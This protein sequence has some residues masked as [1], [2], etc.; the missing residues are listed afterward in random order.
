MQVRRENK[1]RERRKGRINI[2]ILKRRN[3]I[4]E[5]KYQTK[6]GST[7]ARQ[8]ARS[9]A[10]HLLSKLSDGPC[11]PASLPVCPTL[12]PWTVTL[13]VYSS[14]Q[15]IYQGYCISVG[16]SFYLPS[17]PQL[18]QMAFQILQIGKPLVC[19]SWPQWLSDTI[20]EILNPCHSCIFLKFKFRTMWMTL[21]G[22]VI[23]LDTWS[24]DICGSIYSS[25]LYENI[26]MP[27]AFF[28]CRSL[29]G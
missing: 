13:P 14:P 27:Y 4:I 22:L 20:G 23:N 25:L 21:T 9:V 24:I 17:F 7:P 2:T 26:K 8:T 29:A 28:K 6:A 11:S 12:Y 5:H 1:R 3:K 15:Q 19:I 16:F 18:Q 10:T